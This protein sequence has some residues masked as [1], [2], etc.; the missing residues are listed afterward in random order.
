LNLSKNEPDFSR[1][2]AGEQ[3]ADDPSLRDVAAFL[4]ALRTAYP[5]ASVDA[6]REQHLAA[7]SREVRLVGAART[8]PAASHRA[9]RTVVTTITAAL[10]LLTVGAGVAT[11]M[12]GN[13]LTILP[14]LRLGPPEAPRSGG[15]TAGAPSHPTTTA[16]TGPRSGPPSPLP[17][18][19]TAPGKSG[20]DHTKPTVLPTNNGKSSEAQASHKPTALPSQATA[21]ADPPAK[22]RSSVPPKSTRGSEVEA[23]G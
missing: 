16:T 23:T 15:P 10:A 1:L 19:T 21:K 13:P 4:G 9:R 12:G 5:P 17:T 18:P 14:G 11:A 6:V 2:L 8:R 3:P 7:V 20:E 22:G